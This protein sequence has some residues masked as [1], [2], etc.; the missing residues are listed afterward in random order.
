MLLQNESIRL[1]ALEPEDLELLYKW[2][3]DPSIWSLGNTMSP[4]SRYVLKDYISRSHLNIYEL[5]QLRL[6]IELRESGEAI[7]MV[8]LYDFDPHNRKAGVGILLDPAYRGNGTAT[9]ALNLLIDY[10]F[11]FLKL[12]QLYAYTPV[13]NE[14]SRSLFTRSHFTLSGVLSDWI[15]TE[16]GFADVMI[17]QR[18]SE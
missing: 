18:V 11:T 13:K 7:G 5:K 15:L 14:P 2:E 4:Y 10:A 8:D 6:M 16:D 3:N 12:R 1:R 17:M 9:G